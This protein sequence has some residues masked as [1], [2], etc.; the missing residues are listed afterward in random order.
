MTDTHSLPRGRE[1]ILHPC[2]AWELVFP[3]VQDAFLSGNMFLHVDVCFPMQTAP[4]SPALPCTLGPQAQ[5]LTSHT[6]GV[7]GLQTDRS[8]GGGTNPEETSRP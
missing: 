8:R 6:A 3:W 1:E 2:A 4:F 5:H 7:K